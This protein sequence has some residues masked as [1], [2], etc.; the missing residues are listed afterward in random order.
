MAANG[1]FCLEGEWDP[2][3]RE[4]LSVLPVL[5][6]L[7]RLGEIKAIHRDVATRAE[8]KHYLGKWS[9]RRYDDYRV[10]F[11]ATHG[12]KGEL[13]WSKGNRTSLVELAEILGDSANGCYIY[14]GACLTLFDDKESR[15][16]VEATGAA[17]VLG[18]RKSVD[19]IE[20]AAFETVLLTWVAKHAG[21]PETLF[22]QLMARHGGLASL[23]KFVMVTQKESLRSQ[24]KP[25]IA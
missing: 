22:K 5:E 23:Y 24:D 1:I 6:Y 9:Q 15:K 7:E 21:R 18:Y 3:L 16:F 13:T 25:R 14:L 17:A 11:L 8:L 10:L 4:R 19:F 12:D 2:D 20:G